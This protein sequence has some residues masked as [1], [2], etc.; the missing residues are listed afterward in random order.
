MTAATIGLIPSTEHSS[1]PPPSSTPDATNMSRRPMVERFSIREPSSHTVSITTTA[2]PAVRGP[3]RSEESF[4]WT[5]VSGSAT[6]YWVMRNQPPTAS[7]QKII[8]GRSRSASAMA[9]ALMGAA[10]VACRPRSSTAEV[11]ANTR[12]SPA[13]IRNPAFIAPAA[14]S[15]VPISGP[16]RAAPLMDT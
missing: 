9:A 14:I 16:I 12:C 11:T 10:F 8:S 7:E 5:T 13:A 1:Q 15:A 3:T 2:L 6:R 4:W